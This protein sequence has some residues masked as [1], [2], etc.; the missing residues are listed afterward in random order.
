MQMVPPDII[1]YGGSFDPPHAGHV[2]SVMQLVKNFPNASIFI[3][4]ACQPAGIA[5][6]HKQTIASFEQRVAM[7][8][9]AFHSL[10][11]EKQV[12]ITDIESKMT[13]PNFTYKV[14][15]QL[16]LENPGKEIGFLIGQDQ[17]SG[18]SMWKFPLEIIKKFHLIVVRRTKDNAAELW[19]ACQ[20]TFESLGVKIE[21]NKDFHSGKM[22]HDKNIYVL[23]VAISD[24]E[25][26]LIRNE[27]IDQ[28]SSATFW[29]S[30]ELKAY[31]L[32]NELYKR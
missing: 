14:L 4:P 9:I 30:N 7:C 3:G 32:S 8:E 20:Q 18:F 24:A 29:L 5:G 16:A 17:V 12:K 2:E 25:S 15:E 27:G 11:S 10:L 31:I 21:W 26:S 19:R 1:F 28:C 6:K 22:G 23:D 13:I